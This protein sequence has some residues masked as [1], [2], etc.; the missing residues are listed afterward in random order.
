MKLSNILTVYVFILD[1]LA[2]AL[3][4]TANCLA[5]S[6]IAVG[7]GTIGLVTL[8]LVG[9]LKSSEKV[10]A[11]MEIYVGKPDQEEWEDKHDDGRS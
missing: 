1:A 4:L 9:I 11:R 7:I 3:L 5:H 10:I 6:L 2:I 8:Y